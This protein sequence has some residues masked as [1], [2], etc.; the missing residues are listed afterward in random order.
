MEYN[1]RIVCRGCLNDS[2]SHQKLN[3]IIYQMNMFYRSPYI[4]AQTSP[5][6]STFNSIRV[7]PFR[8]CVH[9]RL[10]FSN[11]N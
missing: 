9:A 11:S 10:H 3:A 8:M 2:A 1:K 5:V 7:F 6:V 4:I